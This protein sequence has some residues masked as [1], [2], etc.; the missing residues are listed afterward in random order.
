MQSLDI[1]VL[2]RALL[3]A[4]SEQIWLCT[5][6][7]TYGSSPRPPGAIMVIRQDGLFSGSL[8]GGCVE[9]DFIVRIGEGAF[10]Q[11]SQVIRYGDGGFTPNRALPCGGVLDILI[12]RL[13]P[14]P[15]TAAYLAEMRDAVSGARTLRKVITLPDV[16]DELKPCNYASSTVAVYDRHTVQLTLAAAPR[17]IIAGLS[18]VAI[19]CANYAVALGFETVVCENREDVLKNFTDSLSKDVLLVKKFPA[20]YLEQTGC[21]AGTAIV[22]LTHD[23]RVDDLTLMEAVNTPAFYIGAMGSARN[24]Q[25]RR[26]RLQDIAELR[27]EQLKRI[28]AP[29]GID[30][31]SKTP[32]EIALSVMADIVQHK[33]QFSAVQSGSVVSPQ[34][35]VQEF[36]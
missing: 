15:H 26:E 28:H 31:G 34:P 10:S 3:W 24:S 11:R 29:I 30:I 22:S 8:S 20:N 1:Q 4:Q 32:A 16:C 27:P 33:N 5:V 12:E 21:H 18:V 6:L 7:S 17:L 23:P 13:S 2:D 36:D 35:L 19:F 9:E 14:T 25:R